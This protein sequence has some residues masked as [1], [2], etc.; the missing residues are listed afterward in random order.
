MSKLYNRYVEE[1]KVNN[2]CYY[3]FKV[4]AFYV[5][6][7]EDAKEISKQISLKL[8]KLN[9]DIVKCG[10][11]INSLEK[12]LNIFNKLGIRI[13]IIDEIEQKI[14]NKT[15]NIIKRISIDDITPIKALNI[16]N[17]LKELVNE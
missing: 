1:K 6:L 4:G 7:D 11:P 12:Y 16:L 10:F 3:L 5:F 8:T 17:E 9:D 13:K 2:N 15:I 14:D